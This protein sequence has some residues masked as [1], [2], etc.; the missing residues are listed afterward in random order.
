MTHPQVSER[1]K[2]A[3]ARNQ[4][5]NDHYSCNSPHHNVNEPTDLGGNNQNTTVKETSIPT[6]GEEEPPAY[7]Q[8]TPSFFANTSGDEDLPSTIV[9]SPASSRSQDAGN[10]RNKRK[11]PSEFDR[12][13]KSRV[14]P[15]ATDFVA[16]SSPRVSAPEPALRGQS[17]PV[18]VA[19][20]YVP[21][22]EPALRGQS[23]SVPVAYPHIPQAPD[24]AASTISQE[25]EILLLSRFI[26]RIVSTLNRVEKER[27]VILSRVD[28]LH[29]EVASLGRGLTEQMD[30][31][32]AKVED[33]IKRES[34]DSK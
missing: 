13:P 26:H 2:R 22:P 20:P 12:L 25:S 33:L 27:E 17:V 32:N 18:P 4:Q 28:Q 10:V 15:A 11:A 23:V 34:P 3:T 6:I 8:R 7:C 19:S 21:D 31:L 29:N 16:R 5:I 1:K 30:A 14:S 24:A 9:L